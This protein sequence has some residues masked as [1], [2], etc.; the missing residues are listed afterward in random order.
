VSGGQNYFY[1]TFTICDKWDDIDNLKAVFVR[2]GVSKLIDLIEVENGLE[3]QIPWEVMADKGSF[4]VGIFGG[5]RLLTDYT[6]VIV[7]QGC[8]VEGESPL[9]P[10]PDW[11]TKIEGEVLK[12]ENAIKEVDQLSSTVANISEET[13]IVKTDVEGIQKQIQEEAHF[14]G[15]LSTNEKIQSLPATPNDFAYSAESGTVWIYAESGWEETDTPVPDKATPAGNAT[16]LVNGEASAGKSA[17]FSREDHRHP[18]DPTR[19]SAKDLKELKDKEIGDRSELLDAPND[20]LVTAINRAFN[21]AE[22]VRLVV[23]A[24]NT[25]VSTLRGEVGNIG[26]ALD[27][28]IAIQNT[29]IGGDSV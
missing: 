29:L 13:A 6:Y 26:T 27:T 7:K 3:C 28:I 22:S 24:L 20:D 25:D 23:D 18:T 17:A 19:A 2:D 15:Y 8:V 9:P 12:A 14:R 11:F 10:T 4:H 1:A 21:N 16:P 5:D